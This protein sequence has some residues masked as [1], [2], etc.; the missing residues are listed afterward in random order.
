MSDGPVIFVGFRWANRKKTLRK[1]LPFQLQTQKVLK[2]LRNYLFY[3]YYYSS[4]PSL[5]R[6]EQSGNKHALV[7]IIINFRLSAVYV[8]S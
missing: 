4:R 5:E 1:R 2:C 8:C 6:L 3:N 7:R